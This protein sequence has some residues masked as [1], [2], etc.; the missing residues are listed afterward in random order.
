MSVRETRPAVSEDAPE[1]DI[2]APRHLS[3]TENIVLTLKVLAGMAL[4]GGALWA[5]NFWLAP[6]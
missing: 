4:V 5:A 2:H 3:A 1:Q 6:K